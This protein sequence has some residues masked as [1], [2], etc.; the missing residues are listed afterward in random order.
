MHLPTPLKQ[1]ILKAAQQDFHSTTLTVFKYQAE[2]NPVYRQFLQL[3]DTDVHTI[4][5]IDQIPFLPIELFKTHKV[6]TKNQP[7][8]QIFESSGTTSA[9][10]AHHYIADLQLYNKSCLQGF[11]HFYG[12]LKNYCILALLPTYLERERASLVHMVQLFI[13]QSDCKYSGF[14]LSNYDHLRKIIKKVK[15]QT[16]RQ[17]LLIGVAFALW[18]MA[19]KYPI[20]LSGH[21]IME[22]GGM[23]GK[24]REIIRAELH[25]ILQSGFNVKKV[26][27]EYGM[28]ELLSQAYALRKGHFSSPPWMK[29]RIRDIY[30]PFDELSVG[31]TG[32]IN[33]IDLANL[34]SCSFIATDDLGRKN[35]KDQFEVLGRIDHSDRRGCNLML[36]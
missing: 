7:T 5:Y 33:I 15:E 27:S 25:Q 6:I 17:I 1:D 18:E 11:K 30:D 36:D 10:S 28:T 13:N 20:D 24:R 35:N 23:K 21:I 32:G 14:F 16:D 2:Y 26:H 9:Q 19:E 8:Q 31:H 3:L 29:V 34:N 4:E 12:S 22:T